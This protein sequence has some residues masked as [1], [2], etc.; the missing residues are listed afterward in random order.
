MIICDIYVCVYAYVCAYIRLCVRACAHVQEC[1]CVHLRA[2]DVRAH[3][4][5]NNG[6]ELY[7]H[8]SYLCC[9]LFLLISIFFFQLIFFGL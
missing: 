1:A 2:S 6:N 8:I 3:A 7:V 9:R 5:E 4:C